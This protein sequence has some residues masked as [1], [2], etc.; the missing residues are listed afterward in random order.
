MLFET[1]PT[2]GDPL[3]DEPVPPAD[4][5]EPTPEPDEGP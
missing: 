2:P 5:D 4:P 1:P 3:P